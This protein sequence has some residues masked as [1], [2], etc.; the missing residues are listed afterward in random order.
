[1]GFCPAGGGGKVWELTKQF[2]PNFWAL[3]LEEEGG[4]RFSYGVGAGDDAG[5]GVEIGP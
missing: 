3:A 2:P 5:I 4:F 1:M